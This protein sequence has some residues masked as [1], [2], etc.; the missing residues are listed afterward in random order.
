MCENCEHSSPMFD[1]PL[2][3]TPVNNP[4][5]LTSQKL[6]SLCYIFAAGSC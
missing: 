5:K 3:A 1:V 2:Y 6:E 4:I